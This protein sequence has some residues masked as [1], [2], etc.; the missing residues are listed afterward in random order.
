MYEGRKFVVL[1]VSE[2][3]N[4]DFSQ[5]LE[6]S[7]ETLRLSTDESKTFIK[8]DGSMPSSVSSLTTKG[9]EMSWDELK[10]LL[11]TEAW[12]AE[13]LPDLPESEW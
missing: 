9:D 6:T 4:I 7:P 13:V 8:Y 2:I 12:Q 3:D 5:V 10:V 11:G 1:D